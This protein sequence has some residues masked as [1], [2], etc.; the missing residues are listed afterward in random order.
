MRFS[1][2]F[3]AAFAGISMCC[4]AF[5]AQT[6][7]TEGQTVLVADLQTDGAAAIGEGARLDA[8]NPSHTE[9]KSPEETPEPAD[10]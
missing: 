4:I 6:V 2:F 9:T 8:E 10:G 3:M 5:S 7:G 1:H